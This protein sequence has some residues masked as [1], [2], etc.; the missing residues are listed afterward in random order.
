MLG[1]QAHL[2]DFLAE[3]ELI[4]LLRSETALPITYVCGDLRKLHAESL[5]PEI[6]VAF[7][8]RFIHYLRYGEAQS[9]VRSIA[10]R[11][12]SGDSFFISASGIDSELGQGYDRSPIEHRYAPL[13]GGMKRKH[14]IS[15][16][17]CLYSEAELSRLMESCGYATANVWR[18]EFGNI[19]GVFHR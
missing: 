3:S 19:K 8:Q 15:Q 5:P 11:Q 2:Y 9:L 17:V 18:S 6:S 12:R 4:R 16:S 14:G 10:T 7:S 1:A 13:S